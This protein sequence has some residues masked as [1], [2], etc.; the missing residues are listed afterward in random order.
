MPNIYAMG[1][2]LCWASLPAAIGSEL[3]GLSVA[4][5]LGKIFMGHPTAG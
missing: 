1:A 5:L 4:A 2:V 3:T